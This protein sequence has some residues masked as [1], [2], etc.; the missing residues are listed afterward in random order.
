M[1][2]RRV[3]RYR[4]PEVLSYDEFKEKYSYELVNHSI[5]DAVRVYNTPGLMFREKPM[6]HEIVLDMDTW[7]TTPILSLFNLHYHHIF[8]TLL[9]HYK[10]NKVISLA[11]CDLLSSLVQ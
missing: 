9:F 11:G 2:P 6:A 7:R 10:K 1:F 4:Q 5:Q 8:K 3:P